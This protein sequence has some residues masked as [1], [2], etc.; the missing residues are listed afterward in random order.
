M[1]ESH[2]VK[3][4]TLLDRRAA[5]KVAGGLMMGSALG[6]AC[7]AADG[8][9]SSSLPF[10]EYSR[11]DGLGLAELVRKK[12][13]K[14]EELLE[15]GIARAEAVNPKINAIVVELYEQA[16]Q[17]IKQ[18]LPNGLELSRLRERRLRRGGRACGARFA[19]QPIEE[20]LRP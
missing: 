1:A 3:Q 12:E 18:G 10:D 11:H 4:K 19:A 2:V 17:E 16:R 13:V 5:M 14:P 20:S 7:P 9:V 6:T 15:A 8:P